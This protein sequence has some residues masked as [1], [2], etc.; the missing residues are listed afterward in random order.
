MGGKRALLTSEV[1]IYRAQDLPHLPGW[2]Q[3]REVA[4]NLVHVSRFQARIRHEGAAKML[5]TPLICAKDGIMDTTS[6]SS[7]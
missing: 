5:V 6:T 3:Y 4:V 1:E 2:R 7:Y